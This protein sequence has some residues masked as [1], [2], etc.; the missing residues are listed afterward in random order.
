VDQKPERLPPSILGGD[1]FNMFRFL[2]RLDLLW[3]L[4]DEEYCYSVM[5]ACYE[6]G[7]MGYDLSFIENVRLFRRLKE[8][9]GSNQLIGFGNPTWEQGVFLNGRFLHYS[10]DRI[11]RTLVER[12]WPGDIAKIVE[13]KLSHEAVLV[14]G[15]DRDASLLSEKEIESI[16]LDEEAFLRRLSIFEDCQYILMGGADA[17]YLVSLGRMDIVARMADIVREAGYIPFLLTQYPSLVLPRTEEAGLRVDGYAVPLNREWSWFTRDACLEAVRAT[18]KPVIAFMPLASGQL[19]K[20][21]RGALEW[22]YAEAGVEAILYGT[23]TA[24][25]ARETTRIAREAREAADFIR[26]QRRES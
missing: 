7:G 3:K 11:I 8:E 15:Y 20:D 24:E 6:A 5:K 14:F 22:L 26:K 17:D 4:F 19:K 2:Y 9:T 25:H 16:Y 18:N 1:P 23:A 12:L 10:R 13:E 21:V